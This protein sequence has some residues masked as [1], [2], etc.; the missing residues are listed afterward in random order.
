[1]SSKIFYATTTIFMSL[2]KCLDAKPI[3]GNLSY[4]VLNYQHIFKQRKSNSKL[5][6]DIWE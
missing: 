5:N 4:H 3:D 2:H 6:F 1:M